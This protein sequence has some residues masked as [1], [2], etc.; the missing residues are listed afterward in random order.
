MSLT[1]IP[2][3]P[4]SGAAL[5][6]VGNG[7]TLELVGRTAVAGTRPRVVKDAGSGAGNMQQL[8][9]HV[10]ILTDA[11]EEFLK[12]VNEM[13]NVS[14]AVVRDMNELMR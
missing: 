5:R 2:A 11:Y 8:G 13:I 6:R 10:T 4:F 1:P 14:N 3:N 12:S 9:A 7:S